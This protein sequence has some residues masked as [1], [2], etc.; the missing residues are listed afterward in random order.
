[1]RITL[2]SDYAVRIVYYLAKAG[3]KT[4][5]GTISEEVGVTVRFTLKILGKLSRAGIVKS[6]KGAAGGYILNRDA[7][8]IT[9]L[10]IITV[11][12]GPIALNK[13]IDP[14]EVCTRVDNKEACPFHVQFK[15][16]GKVVEDEF[17]A[18]KISDFVD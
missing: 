8:E 3:V 16:I 4:D 2:E 17:A 9:L 7:S 10:D 1:M 5:A 15:R 13:C 11:I 12:D 6:F 14:D 18:V